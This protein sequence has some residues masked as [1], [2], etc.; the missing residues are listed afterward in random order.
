MK[1][2]IVIE[3]RNKGITKGIYCLINQFSFC[4]EVTG[5]P[6]KG[7][8]VDGMC[9]FYQGFDMILQTNLTANLVSS[10]LSKWTWR[11]K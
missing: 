7:R 8:E 6:L 1:N 9:W 2:K 4:D 10:G 5:S 11:W 3:N